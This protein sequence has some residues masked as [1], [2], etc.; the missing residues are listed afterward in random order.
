MA[1]RRPSRGFIRP[2]YSAFRQPVARLT[3]MPHEIFVR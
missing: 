2:P 1:F 3:T